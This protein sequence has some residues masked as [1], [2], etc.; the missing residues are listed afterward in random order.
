MNAVKKTKG[1]RTRAQILETA[2]ELFR[3]KGYEETTMRVIAERAE[4]SLGNAYYYFAS[5]EHLVHAFYERIQTETMSAFEG[6]LSTEESFKGRLLNVLMTELRIIEPYHRLS[7]ALF[8]NAAD[9]ESPL[10]PFGKESE[11]LRNRCIDMYRKLM[12]G[13]KEQIPGDLQVELPQLLWLFHMGV[14]LFWIHDRSFGRTRTHNLVIHAVDLINT[15]VGVVSLPLMVP[16]R[17]KILTLIKG[18]HPDFWRDSTTD[19]AV[20]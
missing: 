8:K 18:V 19:T 4:V 1:E 11:P 6:V 10:S 17:K 12:T 9:P 15:L 3:E 16:V 13:A 2:I 5:K 20:D 14:I 7:V